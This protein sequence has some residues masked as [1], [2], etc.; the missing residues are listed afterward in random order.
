MASGLKIRRMAKAVLGVL[1]KLQRLLLTRALAFSSKMCCC[2]AANGDKVLS[3]PR[4]R[5][6]LGYIS[7]LGTVSVAVTITGRSRRKDCARAKLG[8]CIQ[9]MRMRTRNFSWH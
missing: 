3:M 7:W 6:L 2:I 1:A 5:S 8:F 4:T 9:R